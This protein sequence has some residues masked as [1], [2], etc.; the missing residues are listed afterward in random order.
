VCA[1][2]KAT[3]CNRT[4][5]SQSLRTQRRI[6]YLYNAL[7]VASMDMRIGKMPSYLY[8]C[9]QCGAELELNH[10]VN[11]HGDSS[12]LCCSYPMARVFSAPSIIFKGT[13]WGKDV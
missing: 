13:G 2:L 5:S 7:A 4:Q 12:P 10:P 9:D 1:P 3:A 6:K 8:R 11:T